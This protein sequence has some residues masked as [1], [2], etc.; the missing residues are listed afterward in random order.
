MK[1]ARAHSR[2]LIGVLWL[3][4]LASVKAHRLDE[5]L[6]AVLIDVRHKEILIQMNLTPGVDVADDVLKVIDRN[7][8]GKISS[9]E[10]R[11][12]AK[13]LGGELEVRLD[14]RLL[15][16]EPVREQFDPVPELKSGE[17]NV[18]IE[19]RARVRRLEAGEHLL[20]IENRHQPRISVYLVNALYP[21]ERGIKIERQERNANQSLG[22]IHFT[23]RD[24]G[25]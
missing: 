24:G 23:V 15:K 4:A 9:A 11:F 3:F 1:F 22:K 21:K 6:Q 12:Y 13:A 20:S 8:D 14:D 19:M 7:A 10:E 16:L 2:L 25:K 18:R 17:G 5:Y